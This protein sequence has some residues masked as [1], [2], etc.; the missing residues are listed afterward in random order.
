MAFSASHRRQKLRAL[1]RFA[2]NW[3]GVIMSLIVFPTNH[4]RYSAN[5]SPEAPDN[6]ATTTVHRHTN[7]T[8][9][10]LLDVITQLD[11]Q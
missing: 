3:T 1:K 5:I 11:G 8:L 10:A 4:L 2:A 6:I 9:P 7:N